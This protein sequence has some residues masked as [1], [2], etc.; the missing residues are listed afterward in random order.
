MLSYAH[1]CQH[2]IL[3]SEGGSHRKDA[4]FRCPRDCTPPLPHYC[5]SVGWGGDTSTLVSVFSRVICRMLDERHSYN[6]KRHNTLRGYNKQGRLTFT[7]HV[8]DFIEEDETY[9]YPG[10]GVQFHGRFHKKARVAC[11]LTFSLTTPG[12][13]CNLDPGA[14]FEIQV[15]S[16]C[17]FHS[18][19]TNFSKP[20]I[21]DAHVLT[22]F[23]SSSYL[24]P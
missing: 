2:E 20:D 6:K 9:I 17:V 4:V 5:S 11:N 8:T 19:H 7:I 10:N 3:R 24:A 21:I 14:V 15:R 22:T 12:P 13:R 18:L 1:H 23:N 16:F